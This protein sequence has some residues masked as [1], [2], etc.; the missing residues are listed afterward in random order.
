LAS[1]WTEFEAVVRDWAATGEPDPSLPLT[2][3]AFLADAY[4]LWLAASPTNERRTLASFDGRLREIYPDG[5]PSLFRK[6]KGDIR[7]KEEELE[8]LVVALF[9]PE[10]T[11]KLGATRRKELE[12]LSRSLIQR[13]FN[14]Q[15]DFVEDS[16]AAWIL[17]SRGAVIVGPEDPTRDETFRTLMA[18]RLRAAYASSDPPPPNVPLT[19]WV[20][21]VSTLGADGEAAYFTRRALTVLASS[22]MASLAVPLLAPAEKPTLEYP[23]ERQLASVPANV[24]IAVRGAAGAGKRT[25]DLR[26]HL[27]QSSAV[28]FIGLPPDTSSSQ[29]VV[30]GAEDEDFFAAALIPDPILAEKLAEG[31]AKK[32]VVN[33]VLELFV[34]HEVCR[35]TKIPLRQ[36]LNI[37]ASAAKPVAELDVVQRELELEPVHYLY[38]LGQGESGPEVKEQQL[39]E[40]E[41]S[42]TIRTAIFAILVAAA[43]R[44]SEAEARPQKSRGERGTIGSEMI[45]LLR[46]R[47]L[48]L[49]TIDEFLNFSQWLDGGTRRT[50]A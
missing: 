10:G 14:R 3:E 2:P 49:M 28:C 12:T 11:A 30:E 29:L 46:S 20:I 44:L 21:D 39:P 50:P 18:N 5:V 42:V 45:D 40:S 48:K 37:S 19:L 6:L 35:G 36:M 34:R 33:Q 25:E 17:A 9:A 15:P 47:G 31:G 27:R 23:S 7:P 24:R 43:A 32:T 26:P 13:L 41:T 22:L 1:N 8:K 38:W 4:D 16:T